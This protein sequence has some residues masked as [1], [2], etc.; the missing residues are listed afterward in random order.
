MKRKGMQLGVER[1][2]LSP[3][4][5]MPEEASF[6]PSRGKQLTHLFLLNVCQLK[7]RTNVPLYFSIR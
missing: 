6:F 3:H 1:N 4:A 5:E 2:I 7:N